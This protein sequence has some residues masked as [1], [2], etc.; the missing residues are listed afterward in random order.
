MTITCW[1]IIKPRYQILWIY[2]TIYWSLMTILGHSLSIF[3]RTQYQVLI[4]LYDP[5]YIPKYICTNH[6][7]Y[8]VQVCNAFVFRLANIYMCL[9]IVDFRYSFS[10]YNTFF[11]IILFIFRPLFMICKQSSSSTAYIVYE[12]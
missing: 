10:E 9:V 8:A 2:N 1:V 11:H 3:L 4:I 6:Q 12:H 5:A 7:Y